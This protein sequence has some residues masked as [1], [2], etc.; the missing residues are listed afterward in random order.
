MTPRRTLELRTKGN[1]PVSDPP[2]KKAQ[3][4]R[5]VIKS[6]GKNRQEIEKERLGRLKW[7]ETLSVD[8]HN[9]ETRLDGKDTSSVNVINQIK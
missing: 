8:P 2:P 7:L 4:G 6:R 3:P 1:R 5:D 9:M